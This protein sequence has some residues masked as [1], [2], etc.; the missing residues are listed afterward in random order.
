MHHLLA[1]GISFQRDEFGTMPWIRVNMP[2][3]INTRYETRRFVGYE[4]FWVASI[5]RGSA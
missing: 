5:T 4:S 3:P 2:L 1:H